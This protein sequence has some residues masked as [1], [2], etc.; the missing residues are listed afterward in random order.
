M[1]FIDAFRVLNGFKRR[2]V[3]RD[4]VVIGAVAATAYM[5]PIF[6]EDIDIIVLVDS[7]EEYLSTFRRIAELAEAQDGMHQ[8]LGG[9]PVQLFP[10]TT[11]PLYLSTLEGARLS[12]IGRMRVKIASPEHLVLLYLEAFRAKD[13]FRVRFLL[14]NSDSDQLQQLL[15]R[16]DDEEDTLASRLHALL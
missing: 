6:T 1:S 4:Y 14:P 9:V 3:I 16:F 11:K 5:E 10:S 7:D 15:E 8:T 2:R 12:R 13:Q